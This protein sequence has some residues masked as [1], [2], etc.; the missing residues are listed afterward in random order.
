MVCANCALK[1]KKLLNRNAVSA[2]TRRVRKGYTAL[3]TSRNETAIFIL[4]VK[5]T[6]IS[7]SP[8]MY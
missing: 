7:F 1:W 4:T 3:K 5:V 6:F 2:H 8:L